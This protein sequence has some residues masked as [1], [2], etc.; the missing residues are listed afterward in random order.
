[1]P[2]NTSFPEWVLEHF[3]FTK[4]CELATND[5]G[6]YCILLFDPIKDLEDAVRKVALL[7]Q[8]FIVY[9]TLFFV[10]GFYVIYT[11]LD[12]TKNVTCY[13]EV[14]DVSHFTNQDITFKELL[15]KIEHVEFE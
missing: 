9:D 8:S 2:L 15:Q 3:D 7:Y 10:D 1:M 12:K 6:T 5:H 11:S 4:R 13:L 14:L